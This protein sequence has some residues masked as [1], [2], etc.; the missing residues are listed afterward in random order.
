MSA[1]V[2]S[3]E[4]RTLFYNGNRFYAEGQ[5]EQALQE[6]G[7][8]I[9]S[10]VESGELHYNIGNVFFKLNRL[11]EAVLHYEKARKFIP[12]D[13]DLLSN[14]EL[15]NISLVDRITP[16]PEIFYIRYWNAF[17]GIMSIGQWK[18]L[19]FIGWFSAASFIILL[20]LIT[21]AKTRRM[22]KAGLIASIL[23]SVLVGAVFV[24]DIIMDR[25]NQ[26]G[27]VMLPE[28]SAFASPSE[29]G[30]E[31]FMIHEG[32]KVTIKRSM[33]NWIEVRLADGNVGWIPFDS[34]EII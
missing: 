2:Y 23:V 7:K 33:N 6:Y 21:G 27:I 18:V 15:I 8:I 5:Y 26:S 24:S 4:A 25:G 31:V 3:Q 19:F 12:D 34:I 9:E 1:P 16:I 30:T 17:R 28:V 10:G 11:G 22:L 32:A 14:I 13:E 29:T 20:F